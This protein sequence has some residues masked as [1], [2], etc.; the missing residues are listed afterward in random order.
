MRSVDQRI[1]EMRINNQQFEK[2]AKESINTLDQLKKSL[3]LEGAEKNLKKLDKAGKEFS[4]EGMAKNIETISSR[5]TTLG[6]IGTNALQDIASSAVRTGKQMID[7]LTLQAPRMGFAEYETQI[8]AIQTILANTKSKGTTLDEINNALDELNSYADQTIY[9]FTQMTESIGRFTAAG[10][11][12]DVSTASIKG[13]S[14]LAAMAGS[15]SEQLN[16]AMFQLS[17]GLSAGTIKLEDWNSLRTANMTNESF[18]ESLIETAR[19]HGIAIDQMISKYG[20]LEYSLQE[21]WL[22]SEVMME[23]LLKFTGDYSEAEWI[24]LGYTEEQAKAIV[25]LGKTAMGAATDV[26]T[27]TQ[28]IDTTKEALQS[29][30]TQSWEI[31]VGDFEEA[32]E[33]WSGV[34]KVLGDIISESADS[35]NAMLQSWKDL[36]GRKAVIE[37]LSNIFKALTNVITPIKEAFR[38]IFP[39]TT[40]RQLA[41]ISKNF[42]NFTKNLVLTSDQMDILKSVFTGIFSTIK[43][44][45]DGVKSF[46]TALS[47]IAKIVPIAVG[48]I[49]SL[50]AVV[51]NYISSAVSASDAS[52]LFTEIVSKISSAVG[53]AVS[54][55]EN[56]V[57]GF[58][59]G[60]DASAFSSLGSAVSGLA[61]Q[62][63]RLETES[64]AVFSDFKSDAIGTV[65]EASGIF[66][67]FG[68]T[69]KSIGKSLSSF[70]NKIKEKLSPVVQ[71]IKDAFEGVTITD[72]IGVGSLAGIS[73]G[74]MKL[75][76]AIKK[77]ISKL[78]TGFG[79]ISEG[80]TETLESVRKTLSAWQTSIKADTL[81]TIAKAV[82][83]LTASLIGLS[84][85]DA[86]KLG[87]GLMGISALFTEVTTA[88]ILLD[89]LN[90][91]GSVKTAASVLG[92]AGA[93]AIMAASLASL[94]QFGNFEELATPL[95]AMAAIAAVLIRSIQLMSAVNTT[96]LMK[97]AATMLVFSASISILGSALIK[98]EGIDY[99][100]VFGSLLTILGVLSELAIF[101]KVLNGTNLSGVST[102]LV[103]LGVSLLAITG[104]IA[105]L[106]SM[107]PVVLSQGINAVAMQLIVL[108]TAMKIIGS[109]KLSGV[110]LSITAMATSMIVLAGAVAL[111]GKM[112]S[113]D[114]VSMATG[115]TTVIALMVA[116]AGSMKLM[117]GAQMGTTALSMIA[118]AA[119]L[120]MLAA[121]IALLGSLPWQALALGIGSL[122]VAIAAI[123]GISVLLAPF[124]AGMLAVAGALALFG[125]TT[126]AI[127]AGISL[128]GAGLALLATSAVAGASALLVSIP[129]IGDALEQLI[130]TIMQVIQNTAPAIIET[131]AIVIQALLTTL[132]EYGPSIG[133]AAWELFKWILHGLATVAVELLEAVWGML[134][135]VGS[136]IADFVSPMFEAGK[137]LV[138]GLVNGVLSLPGA[139][140]DAA[141]NLGSNLL[142]GLKDFLGIHSPSTESFG[143]GGYWDEGFVNGVVSGYGDA[144]SAGAGLGSALQNGTKKSLSELLSGFK[145]AGTQAGTSFSKSTAKAIKKEKSPEEEA[146]EKAK[147]IKEKFE[148]EL[149]GTELDT[150]KLDI[151][152]EIWES[153]TKKT[154]KAQEYY[155]KKKEYIN[156]KIEYQTQI[157]AKAEEKY[158]EMVKTF[159]ESSNYAREAYNEW[160]TEQKELTE[161]GNDLADLTDETVDKINDAYDKMNKTLENRAT[162]LDLEGQLADSMSFKDVEIKPV[163]VDVLAKNVSKAESEY[164]KAVFMFG[165]DSD[166]AVAAYEKLELARKNYSR[167]QDGVFDAEL[168]Y[169]RAIKEYG[170]DS[171][172]AIEALE[173]YEQ[174]KTDAA[175]RKDYSSDLD[176]QL[177]ALEEAESYYRSIAKEFGEDSEEASYAQLLIE[178]AQA[179]LD[180]AQNALNANNRKKAYSNFTSFLR[181][182]GKYGPQAEKASNALAKYK[183]LLEVPGVDQATLDEAYNDYL[184]EQVNLLGIVDNF[185]EEAGLGE[186][187]HA[188]LNIFAKALGDNWPLVTDK[189]GELIDDLGPILEEHN[190]DSSVIDFIKK[191][192]KNPDIET[193][194]SEGLSGLIKSLLSGDNIIETIKTVLKGLPDI[195]TKFLP[196]IGTIFSGESS[197]IIGSISKLLPNI[198]K[199]LSGGLGGI[200]EGIA[201]FLGSIFPK[202]GTLLSGGLGGLLTSLAGG[203]SGILGGLGTTLSG[204][205]GTV[206]TGLAALASSLGPVGIAIAAVGAALVA[207]LTS[208]KGFR[209]FIVNAFG[210]IG[211]VVTGVFTAIKKVGVA[212]FNVIRTAIETVI[213]ILEA[214]IKIIKGILDSIVNTIKTIVNFFKNFKMPSLFGG[215]GGGSGSAE[216]EGAEGGKSLGGA[217]IDGVIQGITNPIGSIVNGI[218]VVGGAVVNGFKNFFGIHSPSKVFEKLGGQLM[219]GLVV[220]IGDSIPKTKKSIDSLGSVVN[221][222]MANLIGNIDNIAE[223]T[224]RPVLDTS[225]I[226]NG[227][228]NLSGLFSKNSSVKL[229][230]NVNGA[231]TAMYA[232]DKVR[233]NQNGETSESSSSGST[234]SFVQNNYSPKAL[235]KSEIYRQTKNQFSILKGRA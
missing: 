191:I 171:E 42:R 15:T 216:S 99:T 131:I 219:D 213:K 35:R 49:G 75:V 145:S 144:E 200:V 221:E 218:K 224:I 184:Q 151:E 94:K 117:S 133:A 223:P 226:T 92:I 38:E 91:E 85:V 55:I 61:N 162:R 230:G 233:E 26:K 186:G 148:K 204:V 205:V 176:E 21:G 24:A 2:G 104:A 41:S 149:K 121:P 47:P 12:L 134:Q 185:A 89:K 141:K 72:L 102:T 172:E 11:D 128:L 115:L 109:A 150:E 214:P 222:E 182:V 130:L 59:Y 23:T 46:A 158:Q 153:Q 165:K 199:A 206:G 231:R 227:A 174:A 34:S 122:V 100:K 37:G 56:F 82:L 54:S 175:R 60:F 106:G 30:W 73:V 208:S 190:I 10:L 183:E 78:L 113:M 101:V 234:Y 211:K 96:G 161:L 63:V 201:G 1:V 88:L 86:D 36:G 209:D 189:W 45:I 39:P 4:L 188:A 116:M 235:S 125:A 138:Q 156:K 80:I 135:D 48:A 29:G 181:G 77:P 187:A 67:K 43:A 132:V 139:V 123:G 195:I 169:K 19:V 14:N 52:E 118:M 168:E 33:L 180:S 157:T 3:D 66:G 143:I 207:L 95:L 147:K 62:I 210:T 170:E 51:G 18:R 163:S 32:K 58:S 111:F 31:I 124:A 197:G 217:I 127:G 225:N 53:S 232:A 93:V 196:N 215:G 137:N 110:A 90:V 193:V 16:T 203:L 142:N 140:V 50:V 202:L 146:E 22:T 17:Q 87:P 136:A 228:K 79:D 112:A 20:S 74:F 28:L 71:K 194:L 81:M 40:G 164:R 70:G 166:Q 6:I 27:F 97:T 76:N 177:S 192:F 159:G 179:D 220:G 229:S 154:V 119:A 68:D 178:Q 105:L 173:A 160:L 120:T 103:G 5:F 167:N 126:L 108:A 84:F 9:N 152:F 212:A 25:E 64:S 8:N 57:K 98:M 198:G 129:I 83:I 65:S 107:D 44:V 114:W 7:A 13:L 155:V 69:L